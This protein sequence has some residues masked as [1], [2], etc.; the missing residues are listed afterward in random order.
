MLFSMPYKCINYGHFQSLIF[1][2]AVFTKGS[3]WRMSTQCNLVIFGNAAAHQHFLLTINP[4]N[5]PCI[6]LASLLK[7]EGIY[8]GYENC[9][10]LLQVSY[11]A[12]LSFLLLTIPM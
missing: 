8:S 6:L 7:A 9:I 11:S 1:I 3:S 12:L 10:H 4:Q 2:H 5:M